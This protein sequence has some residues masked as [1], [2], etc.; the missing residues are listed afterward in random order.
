MI[1]NPNT[2]GIFESEIAEITEL[3]H[4]HG[5]LVYMDGANL[6]AL[7][8]MT[9]PGDFGIDVLHINLHKTFTTPHGGGGPGAG[10]GPEKKVR[11]R[12]WPYPVIETKPGGTAGLT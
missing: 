6:N 12:F 5:A 10:P 8:G 3:L 1:T 2:L 7:M 11:G 4:G 9:R